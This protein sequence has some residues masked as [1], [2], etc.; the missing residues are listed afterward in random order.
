MGVVEQITLQIH[1]MTCAACVRRV[2]R[3]LLKVDGVKAATVNLAT[4]TA[5][6]HFEQTQ[7]GADALKSAVEKAGYSAVPQ[8][9]ES[10]GLL[11]TV[12]A[13]TLGS[14]MMGSMWLLGHA[15]H[16]TIDVASLVLTTLAL[17]WIGARSFR[18]GWL[19]ARD[20]S[21]NMHTLVSIASVVAYLGSAVVTLQPEWARRVLGLT[22]TYYESPIFVMGFVL[23]GKLLEHR[24]RDRAKSTLSTLASLQPSMVTILS[25]EGTSAT[26]QTGSKESS[27]PFHQLKVGTLFRARV[28]ERVATDATITAGRVSVDLSLVTGESVT[29]DKTVG[30]TVR[31]GA[32]VTDGNATLSA[33]T[34]G[35]E[36][37]L[38]QMIS[39]VDQALASKAQ[40]QTTADAIA[41]KFVPAVL[42]VAIITLGI[43]WWFAADFAAGVQHAIAV[44]V[45]ACPC[46]LGLATPVAL[47]V[48]VSAT[49]QHGI[50]VKNASSIERAEKIDTVIFDK[51]GTLTLGT[52]TVREF[53]VLSVE[54]ASGDDHEP[55]LAWCRALT[56]NSVHPLSRA[57]AQWTAAQSA[58]VGTVQSISEIAGKGMQGTCTLTVDGPTKTLRLGSARWFTE[59]GISLTA[60]ERANSAESHSDTLVLFAMDDKL[61]AA[62]ALADQLR[63]EAKEAITAL[64]R[65]QIQQWIVSG[66]RD[67]TVRAVAAE[68][69]ITQLLSEAKPED[70]IAKVRALRAAGRHV[71]MVGDGINDAPALAEAEL[72]IAVSSATDVARSAADLTLVGGDLRKVAIA[73]NAAKRISRTI[74][75]GIYWAFA[76]NVLLIPVAA[77]IFAHWRLE[78]SPSLAAAAM[79]L[80]SVSVVMNALRLRRL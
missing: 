32:L 28:G 1:G 39:V 4:E 57:I 77:G 75:Q 9:A 43:W 31:A 68:L 24:S 55:L 36:N 26:G 33:L 80:S 52:P 50:L 29:V 20:R 73:V 22:Q 67:V 70:K 15:W 27:V 45:V 16:R 53:T 2:E 18:A 37:S 78:L 14:L 17:P 60:L 48:G 62:F 71:A 8:K 76:Y 23:L 54:P 7:C 21:M 79:S 72:A 51:T 40:L 46:A 63:P 41:E 44:L 64:N 3:S 30:D 74:R 49:A 12:V 11:Q 66:D 35:S 47:L 61:V 69:G 34:A 58:A 25:D 56:V 13:L 6:V 38:A 10:D 59:L 42:G 5:Q 65:L 19:A